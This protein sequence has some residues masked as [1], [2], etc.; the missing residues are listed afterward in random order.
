M[1][2]KT[3][4]QLLR[5]QNSAPFGKYGGARHPHVQPRTFRFLRSVRFD[6]WP[7]ATL[8]RGLFHLASE[9]F[10]GLRLR[11]KRNLGE[12]DE[13]RRFHHINYRLVRCAGIGANGDDG[14]FHPRSFRG[15]F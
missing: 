6:F 11:D 10:R 5:D 1:L 2:P 13:A 12:A 3:F 4:A 9:L 8:C 15:D 14:I 7:L